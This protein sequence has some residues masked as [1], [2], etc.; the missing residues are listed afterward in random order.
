VRIE[1][2]ADVSKDA[3]DRTQHRRVETHKGVGG[4]IPMPTRR[5]EDVGG[6]DDSDIN[7]GSINDDNDDD[8]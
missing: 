1:P 6:D 4:M 2:N 5:C 7:D 3:K 8:D